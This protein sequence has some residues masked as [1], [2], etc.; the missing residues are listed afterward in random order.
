VSGFSGLNG[1]AAFSGFSGFSGSGISGFSGSGISGYSGTSGY[2]GA[3]S[4][5]TSGFSGVSGYSGSG[6]SGYSGIGVSGYS[7]FSGAAIS[8]FS[9]YSG[10]PGESSTGP[11]LSSRITVST[12]TSVIA[13]GSTATTFVEG[14]KTYV[15][16]RVATSAPAW[17]V[18]Y[19]DAASQI[20]DSNR[21][22]GID[23]VPGSG[24]IA[25]VITTSGNL[26]QLIT[27]AV[28]GFNNDNP[29]TTST[30]IRVTNNS[31]VSQSISI[32]LT[33]LQL[34]S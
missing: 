32:A 7:G 3:P 23:P 13:S 28:I 19:A 5:A 24:V 31:G 30:Y 16:Q 1:E 11:G 33:L 10:A 29:V 20:L 22:I 25:E 6:I 9:G 21:S 27:P 4:I 12:N 34:E 8:G 15:L 14:F 18:I 2:S 17:V 26:L